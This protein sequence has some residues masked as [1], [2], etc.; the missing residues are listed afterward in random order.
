M[1]AV[2]AEPVKTHPRLMFRG[3][4]LAGLRARAV[5]NNAVWVA[6]KDQVVAPAFANWQANL[7]P[8]LDTGQHTGNGNPHVSEMY[9]MLFAFM[10]LIET[11]PLPQAQYVQAAKECLMAVI[12]PA[13]LG[14]PAPDG[15]GN[16]PPFRH[17]GFALNDRSFAAEAFG[18]TVDWIYPYLTAEEKAKIRKCFLLWW[19]DCNG[20]VYFAPQ[21]PSNL[22]NDPALLQLS[23]P[24][25]R[26]IRLALNNHYANHF[27]QVGLY[28]M[29]FDPADDIP[30]PG[31]G[32]SEPAGAL[33]GYTI[34][35]GPTDWVYQGT[36]ALRNVMGVW[37][38]LTDYALRHD[39]GGGISQEGTQYYS[40]GL[41][42]AALLMLA[43]WS[44]GQTDA[45]QWGPQAVLAGHPFWEQAV[46]GYLAALPCAPRSKKVQMTYMAPF[47]EPVQFGDIENYYLND[48]F[49]KF[50]GPLAI[51]DAFSGA[52]G[53]RLNA[54]RWI[55]AHLPP[56]GAGSL[57][58]RIHN[59]YTEQRFRDAIYYFLLFDPAAPAPSDPRPPGGST[60]FAGF[61]PGGSLGYIASRTGWA[62]NDTFF[63]WRH[64]WQS[65]DHQHA[66]AMS[67]ELWRN[68]VWVTK[69]W[70]A[71]G[72]FDP[73]RSDFANTL[74]VQNN[75]PT[76]QGPGSYAWHDATYGSGFVYGHESDGFIQSRSSGRGYL[77]VASD[78]TGHYNMPADPAVTEVEHVSRSLIW[79]KPDIVVAYDRART[80]Q[81][82]YFKRFWLNLP[83]FPQIAGNTARAQAYEKWDVTTYVNGQPVTQLFSEPR[84]QL[85]VTS[86]L[87]AGATLA[88]DTNRPYSGYETTAAGEVMQARL[89]IDAPGNPA[90]AR[91]LNVLEL[92]PTGGTVQAHAATL[93]AGASG[94]PYQ[95]VAVGGQVVMFPVTLGGGF[96][97]VT[98]QV[99]A[100]NLTHYITG[101]A[102]NT[103]YYAEL[104]TNAG[105]LAVSIATGGTNI[106]SDEGGVLVIGPGEPPHVSCAVQ[107]GIAAEANTGSAT[108]VVSRSGSLGLPLSVYYTVSGSASNGSDYAP[109]PGFVTIPA[110]VVTATIALTAV[111]DTTFEGDETAVVTVLTNAAYHVVTPGPV[112]CVIVDDD[113]PPG[114]ILRLSAAAYAVAENGTSALI[115]VRRE[116]ATA[117]AVSV[118]YTATAGTA[119]TG[120]DF[121][122]TNGTFSWAGGDSSDRTFAVAILDDTAYEGDET[123]S[124]QLSG[125]SGGAA[126]GFPSSATLTILDNEPAPPG[127][128]QLGASSCNIAETG[129]TVVIPVRRVGGSGGAVSVGFSTVAGSALPGSDYRATNGVIAWADHD[130]ADRTV[131]VAVIDDGSYE[132]GA[133]TF[134]LVLSNV[135]GTTLGSP[136]AAT[137][138]ITDDDP[139]PLEF[140]VGPGQPYPTLGSVPWSSVNAGSVVRIHY[141]PP[142]HEKFLVSGSGT[143]QAPVRIVGVPGPGGERPVIDGDNATTA[144]TMEYLAYPFYS[145]TARRSLVAVAG[146]TGQSAGGKPAHVLIQGLEIRN[147]NVT[148]AFTRSDGSAD[149]YS[150]IGG[151]VFVGAADSVTLR[152]CT[153]RN[154]ANGVVAVSGSGGETEVTRNLLVERCHV[155][156]NGAAGAYYGYNIRT[157][158]LGLTL[159]YNRLGRPASGANVANIRDRSSGFLA[160][161]N[162][163]EGGGY[164]VELVEPENAGA[165]I[166]NHASWQ[167]ACLAGNIL[168]NAASDGG[169]IAHIGSAYNGPV[170]ARAG[171]ILFHHNT[172]FADSQRAVTRLFMLDAAAAVVI[173]V[174]NIAHGTGGTTVGVLN[175]AGT[176]QAQLG[177]NW[178]TTGWQA[179]LGGVTGGSNVRTG[180]TPGFRNAAAADFHLQ[181]NSPCMD[182]AADLTPPSSAWPTYAQYVPHQ[183]A[184]LRY[185]IGQA[186]LGAFES[187]QPMDAWRLEHFG[188]DAATPQ[189]AGD[190]GDP[191]GDQA[192]NLLE[193]ITGQNP[194]DASPPDGLPVFSMENGFLTV[195]V[196]R[197][198][199][200]SN[201]TLAAEV[202]SNL[203]GWLSGPAHTVTLEATPTKFKQRDSVSIEEAAQRFMRLR[204]TRP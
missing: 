179:G 150:S 26:Q 106:V 18:L 75:M 30:T 186:D 34:G 102:P 44:A 48:Q 99:Q 24:R 83:E 7:V 43:L 65:I 21:N 149:V 154:C 68:G 196:G 17:P 96:T 69:R 37:L 61:T 139:L 127:V 82:G 28:A 160:F 86:L 5:T 87:P 109:L 31:I 4:H 94:T 100:S 62:T 114:G 194:L 145:D 188:V 161:C 10:S 178:F 144:A 93:V 67:F 140:D 168:L 41:G 8:E 35:N 79:L 29:S 19:R 54:V 36:G 177:A 157:E 142:Y 46:D 172:V 111:N 55:Q 11:N 135:V 134:S 202:S 123:V 112:E 15:N 78:A 23:D 42:P 151:G 189:V 14:H 1:H 141:G 171:S 130:A 66:D 98:Y 147:A 40:N 124:L 63:D 198:S 47:Y 38:Y 115:T 77:H 81:A 58:G 107:G 180:A 182:S 153:I 184:V 125:A 121:T 137:V 143:E 159:R 116:G 97:G 183:S 72:S 85:F 174:N 25:R 71:Y 32:D 108:V 165:S 128:I 52:N 45:A 200:V 173:A 126:V 64:G 56:G 59:C 22:N 120:A 169:T 191:D 117:G 146:R 204:V 53:T 136:A 162:W 176:G 90:D 33:T 12:E 104:Q 155:V 170:G 133:E 118:S 197:S 201:V 92:A 105:V 88:G 185:A 166:T 91:F 2:C 203:L 187:E 193:Y 95:G 195:S 84:V 73:A 16:Y 3:E 110:G 101:M 51:H 156:S 122:P 76:T 138:T 9:A 158:C 57:A 113:P 131:T 74:S 119:A 70:S 129:G 39:G 192:A 152:D 148:N 50:L 132:G 89:R 6:F 181:T 27:R 103:G 190:A 60:F 163:I 164:L 13:S 199:A 80:K 49:I 167:T 20:H 175:P